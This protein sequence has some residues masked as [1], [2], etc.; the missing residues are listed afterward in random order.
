MGVEIYLQPFLTPA[1]DT[2]CSASRHGMIY[3]WKKTP[4]P[5]E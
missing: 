5:L 2:E 4:I 3:P 1:M